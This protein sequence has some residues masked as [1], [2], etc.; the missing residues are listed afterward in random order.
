M[1]KYQFLAI[2]LVSTFLAACATSHHGGTAASGRVK[3]YPLKT[4]IVTDTG[5]YSMG[6]PVSKVYGDQQIK[7]C[8]R[9][10]IAKYEE[11]PARYNAKL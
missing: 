8:C 2:A 10:C 11:N 9:P 1:K 6:S 5:L 7:F 3:P 4:C